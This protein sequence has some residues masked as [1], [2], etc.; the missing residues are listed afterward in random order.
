MGDDDRIVLFHCFFSEGDTA[1]NFD[2]TAIATVFKEVEVPRIINPGFGIGLR[3]A[4]RGDGLT[5]G[6]TIA[7]FSR[8]IPRWDWRRS[9]FLY[10]FL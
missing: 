6:R 5:C 8:W 1:F 10:M 2:F 3:A 4:R 9:Q 7:L